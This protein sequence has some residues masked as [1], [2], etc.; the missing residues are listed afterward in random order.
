MRSIDFRDLVGGLLV[1]GTGA[2][3]AIS[4]SSIPNWDPGSIGP[5][6]VPMVVGII[7]IVLGLTIAGKSFFIGHMVPIVSLRPALAIFAAVIVFALMIRST[8]FIPTLFAVV[9]VA[10]LGSAK[11]RL[12]PVLMLAA[13]VAVGCWLIFLVGLGLPI[14]VI[15]SPF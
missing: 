12:L 4:A 2:A 14:D 15:R 8:G 9:C 7:A 11:S 6:Y 10:A 3:F 1:A 13:A 5:G